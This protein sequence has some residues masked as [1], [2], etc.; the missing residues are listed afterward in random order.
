MPWQISRREPTPATWAKSTMMNGL[1]Q[2]IPLATLSPLCLARIHENESNLY[3]VEL[4]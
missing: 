2:I 4:V 3:F 1:S